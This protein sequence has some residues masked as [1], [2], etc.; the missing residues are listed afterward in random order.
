MKKI[1]I[2][3][4]PMIL[5]LC[6]YGIGRADLVDIS[7]AT[8]KTTYLVDEDVQ[9]FISAYN[10]GTDPVTLTFASDIQ[11]TYWMDEIYDWQE[12]RSRLPAITQVTINPNT[13]HTW[14][15]THSSY[16]MSLYPLEIGTHNVVGIVMAYELPCSGD[17]TP[18]EFKV[19]PEPATLFFFS[20]GTLWII[21]YSKRNNRSY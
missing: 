13:T 12:G 7:V 2:S 11:I 1:D 8:D 19:I 15:L 10:P 18:V 16:E 9:V 6:L 3:I 5:V 14:D 21:R 17:S 20:F 4:L